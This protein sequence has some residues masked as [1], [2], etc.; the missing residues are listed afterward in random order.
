M[1]MFHTQIFGHMDIKIIVHLT[2]Q[3]LTKDI[4]SWTLQSEDY[5]CPV[6]Q[7]LL[8]THTHSTWKSSGKCDIFGHWSSLCSFHG[9]N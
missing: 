9:N 8:W 4:Q 1:H 2:L 7:C 6:S 3:P 5:L